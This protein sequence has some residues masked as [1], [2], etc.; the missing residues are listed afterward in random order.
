MT[1]N[2]LD[3][4]LADY[5][6]TR[7]LS[8]G[9]TTIHGGCITTGEIDV[10]YVYLHGEMIVYDDNGS[11]GGYIGYCSGASLDGIGMMHSVSRGQCIC[12]NGGARMSYGSS[13]HLGVSSN[14]IYA[15][16]GITVD[17]DRSFKYDVGYDLSD[18]YDGVFRA[19][20]PCY[21]KL[22]DTQSFRYHTGFI[23]QEVEEACVAGGLTTQ[24]LAAFVRNDDGI[25]GVRYSEIISLNTAM[26][27]KLMARVDELEKRLEEMNG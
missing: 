1:F 18:K 15:S 16:Q 10:D 8:R 25:C 11:R 17:S 23:A 6:T 14:N 19:L 26:I 20:K 9:T 24:D 4:E 22:T 7:G 3:D 27:Q 2:A 5:A 13:V 21:Y 12:T